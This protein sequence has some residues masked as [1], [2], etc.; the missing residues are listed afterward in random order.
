VDDVADPPIRTPETSVTYAQYV[1]VPFEARTCPEK[2][3]LF[4]ESR[5]A[6]E[7]DNSEI[8]VVARVDVP[9]T[10][11]VLVVVELTKIL[12]VATIESAV[13]PPKN[14]APPLNILLPLNVDVDSVTLLRKPELNVLLEKVKESK[15]QT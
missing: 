9:V 4:F 7:S 13:T 11:K 3:E 10:T 5:K 2:P 12:D 14:S 15:L 8:V 6:P 1:E